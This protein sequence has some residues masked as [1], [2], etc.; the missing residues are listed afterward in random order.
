MTVTLTLHSGQTVT[1][2]AVSRVDQTA[3]DTVYVRCGEQTLTYD[4]TKVQ[5]IVIDA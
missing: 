4:P 3:G 2:I 1:H 5:R